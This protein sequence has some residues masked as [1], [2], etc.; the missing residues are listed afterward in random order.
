VTRAEQTGHV[1]VGAPGWKS[2]D[3]LLISFSEYHD[4]QEAMLLMPADTWLRSSLGHLVLAPPV[5]RPWA[6]G[7]CPTVIRYVVM[8]YPKDYI[9]LNHGQDYPLLRQV[10]RFATHRQLYDFM[11][12]A[13]CERSRQSFNWRIRRLVDRGL[14]LRL[15]LPSF[16]RDFVYS[17]GP[18]GAERLQGMG[19]YGLVG[20]SKREQREREVNILHALELNQI[21]LSLLEKCP[22]ARWISSGQVRS[23]NELTDFG[24]AKDYD[25]VVVLRLEDVEPT[26]RSASSGLKAGATN[27]LRFA[28]EYERTPKARRHYDD[29][30]GCLCREKHVGQLLYLTANYDLLKYVYR[31][32]AGIKHSVYF[33]LVGDW[34]R[35]LLDTP[36]FG[37]CSN[38]SIPLH[39]VL[40]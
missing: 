34:H 22:Q 31:S 18:A 15:P 12:L 32:F 25:A 29:I 40:T 37:S 9:E 5:A 27:E 20:R 24:Y 7:L 11:R 17:I 39:K 19:E 3:S 1:N 10:L 6:A 30:A 28:L 8:G 36:V 2:D 4:Q 14:V 33:G 26:F 16:G 35:L 13:G 38:L 23:Q 21:H